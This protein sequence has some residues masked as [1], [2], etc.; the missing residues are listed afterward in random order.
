M[1][2]ANAPTNSEVG[3]REQLGGRRLLSKTT[4]SIGAIVAMLV[5]LS[6]ALNNKGMKGFY[7]CAVASL[8]L[9]V[10]AFF[11]WLLHIYVERR[12]LEIPYAWSFVYLVAVGTSIFLFLPVFLFVEVADIHTVSFALPQLPLA[13]A[14]GTI[15]TLVVVVVLDIRDRESSQMLLRIQSEA[16]Q[17]IIGLQQNEIVKEINRQ[18][19]VEIEGGLAEGRAEL[20]HL[21]MQLGD[22]EGSIDSMS[23][24]VREISSNAV[25]TLSHR[26]RTSDADNVVTPGLFQLVKTTVKTQPFRTLDLAVIVFLTFIVTE[27]RRFGFVRGAG[28]LAIGVLVL[29]CVCELANTLMRSFPSAHLFIFSSGFVLLQVNTFATDLIRSHWGAKAITFPNL[30]LE[31]VFSAILIFLSSAFP[32]W[33]RQHLGSIAII[34]NSL[35]KRSA[36]VAIRNA[37]LSLVTQE[38]AQVLHGSVQSRLQACAMNIDVAVNEKDLNAIRR[39]L[40]DAWSALVRPISG[41][42][43]EPDEPSRSHLGTLVKRKVDLWK[44]LVSIN[45]KVVPSSAEVDRSIAIAA[46]EVIEEA[47]GNAIR[48]GKATVID[49]ELVV[50]EP[51]IKITVTD[52]GRPNDD[53]S[54]RLIG[55]GSG[56]S[57]VDIRSSGKWSIERRDESTVLQA[58]LTMPLAQGSNP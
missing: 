47:M 15:W 27:I 29:F 25:R 38:A 50:T 17:D 57:M 51:A 31:M 52:N 24:K 16:R 1:T 19:A 43:S 22:I 13:L 34:R 45:W 7:L 8:A 42:L 3:F 53:V 18:V 12:Q 21:R 28:L 40:D 14:S 41:D 36:Q 56:L 6:E 33:R 2:S 58:M 35:D 48:H 44:D 26:L 30:A 9:L 55:G 37:Y 49:I 10:T 4:W 46:G 32:V 11:Q 39:A 5:V 23:S 54:A 20:E